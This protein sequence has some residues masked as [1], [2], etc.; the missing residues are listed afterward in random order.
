[1]LPV[2]LAAAALEAE[3]LPACRVMAAPARAGEVVDPALTTAAPCSPDGPPRRLRYDRAARV[4]RAA[5]DLAP[6]DELGRVFLPERP[7]VLPGERLAVA[8]RIGPITVAREVTALQAG[9][10]GR[11]LFVRDDAGKVFTAPAPKTPEEN[12]R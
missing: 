1:M 9:A 4:A 10:S 3:T 7:R 12:Q 5:V 6:G 11:W 8:A 2:A